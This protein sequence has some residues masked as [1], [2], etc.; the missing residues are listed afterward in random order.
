MSLTQD[1]AAAAA[2]PP[3]VGGAAGGVSTDSVVTDTASG[4]AIE[5][6]GQN[7]SEAGRLIL[8]GQWSEVGEFLVGGAVDGVVSFTPRALS[9]LFVVAVF[10]GLYR[11]AFHFGSR[12]LRRSRRVGAGMEAVL[13]RTLR[14]V[15]LSFVAV[16]G[17]SQLGVNVSALIAGLGIAGLAVGFAAKDS[18]EN[19]ISGVTILM[20]RPFRVGDWVEV[21]GTYGKVTELTLRSTRVRTLNRHEVVFPNVSMVS[22]AV[23]NHSARSTVRVDIPFGVAYKEDLDETRSTV[24]AVV[25]GDERVANSPEPRVV[26]TEMADSAVTLELHLHVTDPG[27]AVPV[28]FDYLE[29]VR[30]A[31]GEAGIEIPFPHLQLHVDGAEGLRKL[32]FVRPAEEDDDAPEEA[33]A[34]STG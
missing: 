14:V 22:Q 26:V 1:S 10:Y 29:K 27:Q 23:T 24:L 19:F 32:S 6:L 11:M 3:Q 2:A 5:A 13:T 16:M 7:V 17:L 4:Q 34:G 9:T 12:V 31:L 33:P 21:D 20:D 18:L 25:E 8:D 28:R 30:K 15:G